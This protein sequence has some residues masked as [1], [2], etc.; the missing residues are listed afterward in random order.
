[1]ENSPSILTGSNIVKTYPAKTGNGALTVLNDCTIRIDSGAIVSVVGPSGSGKSTLL[2]VLGGLDRPDSGEI[3]WNSKSI[4]DLKS[5]ELADF[6]NRQLGFVFQFHHLLPEFSAL[7]NVLMPALI[8]GKEIKPSEERAMELL[9][10]FGIPG[11]AEHRP[12]ELSGGEQQRVSMARAL[13]NNPSLILADEPTGNL[14]DANTEIV[15]EYLFEL[16]EKDGVSIL[17]ITHEKDIAGRCDQTYELNKGKL[18]PL[19]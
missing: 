7:E 3:L 9:N 15:L 17:L 2:H 14:D 1:M 8:A 16:R 5:E 19:N 12:T 18:N 10:R 4:Y 11:R 6:R 13:M